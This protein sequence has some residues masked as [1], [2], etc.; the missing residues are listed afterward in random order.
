MLVNKT[1]YTVNMKKVC[2]KC[3]VEKDLNLFRK[4]KANKSGYANVCKRC[5][6]DYMI[7]YYENNPDKKAEKVRMNTYYK[8]NWK[9]HGITES[10]YKNLLDIHDGN[11]HSCLSRPATNIDHNHGCCP[12]S[13]SCGNCVRGVLCSQCNTSLGLMDDNIDNIKN[14]LRYISKI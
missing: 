9:K 5:H 13:H 11:C 7:S 14:L 12:G 2:T 6:T 10:Q 3:N 8:P 4:Q 1:C